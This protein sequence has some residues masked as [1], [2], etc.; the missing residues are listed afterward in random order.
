MRYVF[1]FTLAKLDYELTDEALIY[2]NRNWIT[3]QRIVVP[4]DAV[5]EAGYYRQSRLARAGDLEGV[6]PV[7][8]PGVRQAV[9]WSLVSAQNT[10]MVLLVYQL[11]G[12][13]RSMLY[14]QMR[15]NDLQAEPFLD[16]LRAHMGDRWRTDE[17]T[18]V[19]RFRRQHQLAT[20]WVWIVLVLFIIITVPLI[21]GVVAGW[22]V[23]QEQWGW[24]IALAAGIA[25]SVAFLLRRGWRRF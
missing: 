8:P 3:G 11:A 4:W 14:L 18:D 25:T 17:I 12:A 23:V 22:Q 5:I 16:D 13:R 7:L 6:A 10:D 9:N 20:W 19:N 15:P 24:Y 21:F 2:H 1:D